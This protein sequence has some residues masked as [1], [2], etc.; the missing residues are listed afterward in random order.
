MLHLELLQLLFK[1]VQCV[2]L[3]GAFEELNL[4][5]DDLLLVLGLVKLKGFQFVPD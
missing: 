3:L 2:V 5:L 4:F 1:L